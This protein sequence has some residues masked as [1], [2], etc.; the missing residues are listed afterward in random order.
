MVRIFRPA[1]QAVALRSRIHLQPH[2]RL[3][4]QCQGRLFQSFHHPIAHVLVGLAVLP[5]ALGGQQDFVHHPQP[6]KR[7]IG[8]GQGKRRPGSR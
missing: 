5:G 3:R 2:H 8:V 7:T 4:T 1:R 6:G